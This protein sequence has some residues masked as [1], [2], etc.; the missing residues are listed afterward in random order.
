MLLSNRSIHVFAV[1]T[2]LSAL[3][4]ITVGVRLLIRRIKSQP[5]SADDYIILAA[6]VRLTMFIM[7]NG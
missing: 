3:T 1:G 4:M 6:A 5:L 2:T 7:G